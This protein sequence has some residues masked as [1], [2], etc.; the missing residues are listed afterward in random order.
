MGWDSEKKIDVMV[1]ER[2]GGIEDFSTVRTKKKKKKK[3]A[4][5]SDAGSCGWKGEMDRRVLG[6]VRGGGK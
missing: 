1:R 5:G 6:R 2:E 4:T 3:K